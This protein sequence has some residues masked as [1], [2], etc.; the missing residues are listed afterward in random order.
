MMDTIHFSQEIPIRHRAGICVVGAGPAGCA[1]AT[2]AAE[3]G[4]DVLLIESGAM[5]GGMSTAGRVPVFMPWSDGIRILCEG[6]GRRILQALK[7]EGKRHDFETGCSIHAEHLKRIY[8][9]FLEEAGARLL[10]YSRLAAVRQEEGRVRQAV[11]AAPGGMFAVE[12]EVFV[13][14]TG[15]GSLAAWAGAPFERGDEHGHVMPSTLCSVW[16]GFDWDAYRRGGIFSHNDERM[17]A[18]LEEAFHSGLL[19]EED[20]HH[21]GV[22]RISRSCAVGNFS[23]VFDVD[24]TDESSLTEGIRRNRKL[25][26]RYETFYRTRIPGFSKAEIID[27]GSVLGVRESRRILG[28]Y[29]LTG[30]ELAALV[31]IPYGQSAVA[32]FALAA[33]AASLLLGRVGRWY[34]LLLAASGRRRRTAIAAAHA[35]PKRVVDKAM[36]ILVLMIFSKYFFNACMTSYFTFFLI[37]KFGLSVQQSQLCLFAYLA[38]FAIGTLLG[39]FLGDRYGRKYVILFSILGSA[40]FSLALPYLGLG[41]T[42]AMAVATGLVIASAFSAIVVYATDL[43]PDKVGM[44]A[45]V[46]FGLMFGLGGI[47]SAFFGWLADLTSIDFIFKVSTWLPLLGIVAVWL[48]DVRPA[49]TTH[50]T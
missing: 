26:A 17:P 14:A 6:Y 30:G 24:S 10:Y 15:D 19:P 8:E 42:V 36:A 18:L 12:A 4:A 32:W 28:D 49:N 40:P 45:G 38:A 16:T 41:G 9:Q 7:E 47:G 23:H 29:V 44:V 2:V 34:A 35:L 33:L 39:G 5:C 13:D 11:F 43:K 27:S 48:P 22:F 20:Y 37:G 46:F 50:T 25:L 1:A 21:T 3:Q 31:V